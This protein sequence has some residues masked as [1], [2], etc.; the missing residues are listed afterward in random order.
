MLVLVTG[1]TGRI[2][3]HVTRAL[4]EE[5]HSVRALAQPDHPRA[6]VIAGPQV[7]FFAGRLENPGALSVACRDVDAV[8]CI[9]YHD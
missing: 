6:P 2:G 9:A 5:G 7:E 3:A 1:A 8:F 4:V